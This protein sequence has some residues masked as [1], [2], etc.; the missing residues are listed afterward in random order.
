VGNVLYPLRSSE[1]DVAF[2]AQLDVGVE[3]QIN[4]RWRAFAGYRAVAVTG[5]A[6]TDSQIPQ[7][8]IDAPEWQ[9]VDT[10]GSLILHGGFAGLECRF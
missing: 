1:D 8:V 3:Y 7:I 2:L 9:D 5:V 6:L 10:N 4:C